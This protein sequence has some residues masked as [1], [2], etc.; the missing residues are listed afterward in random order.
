MK[1]RPVFV[2]LVK[3][4]GKT[5]KTIINAFEGLDGLELFI[6]RINRKNMEIEYMY[7]SKGLEK[8]IMRLIPKP[9]GVADLYYGSI[10]LI[11]HPQFEN[12]YFMASIQEDK[13]K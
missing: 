1:N 7:I 6:D 5:M 2:G 10:L 8:E 3:G 11:V 4:K 9:Q 12:G 13:T